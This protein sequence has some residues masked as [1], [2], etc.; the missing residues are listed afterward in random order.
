[1]NVSFQFWALSLTSFAFIEREIN[2]IQCENFG[3][4][5]R[6]NIVLAGR[7]V[8]L[9][10]TNPENQDIYWLELLLAFTR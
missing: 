7:Y 6:R 9:K 8:I 2:K 3:L 10:V 4:R 5:L 1:M